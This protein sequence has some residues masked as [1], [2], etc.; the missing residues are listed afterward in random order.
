MLF[1]SVSLCLS[2]PLSAFLSLS[3]SL[4]LWDRGAA[5]V[6]KL[7][8]AERGQ[9]R[10]HRGTGAQASE[11]LPGLGLRRGVLHSR[12]SAAGCERR[13]LGMRPDGAPRVCAGR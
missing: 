8:V 1:R 9:R 13:D 12:G 4:S 6:G 7:L 11:T 3:L 2:L 5:A 10:G